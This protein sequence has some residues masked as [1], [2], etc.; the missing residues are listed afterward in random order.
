MEKNALRDPAIT[1]RGGIF[2]I[3]FGGA[4]GFSIGLVIGT[5]AIRRD[6]VE[7]EELHADTR[8]RVFA[9]DTI[10]EA[11]GIVRD[12]AP[13]VEPPLCKECGDPEFSYRHHDQNG[14]GEWLHAFVGP[15]DQIFPH[16]VE[17]DELPSTE[18]P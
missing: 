18:T 13:R 17:G 14:A 11:E 16:A 5:R 4:I 2:L 9:L 6:L 10:D 12:R 1:V 15:D 3:G 7:L 8:T